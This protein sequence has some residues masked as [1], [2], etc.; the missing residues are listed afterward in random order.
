MNVILMK[1]LTSACFDFFI[2]CLIYDIAD[3]YKYF[4]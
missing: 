3:V 1:G 2:A 4:Q